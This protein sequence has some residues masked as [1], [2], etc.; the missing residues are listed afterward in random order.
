VGRGRQHVPSVRRY[1]RAV[2]ASRANKSD[3]ARATALDRLPSVA[4][5]IA[6]ARRTS[7]LH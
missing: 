7:V 6:L 5:L 1:A 2:A 3:A 4:V